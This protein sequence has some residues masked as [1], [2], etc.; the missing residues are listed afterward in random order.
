MVFGEERPFRLANTSEQSD[1]LYLRFIKTDG[2]G[3]KMK[4]DFPKLWKIKNRQIVGPQLLGED[5]TYKI[6]GVDYI[7]RKLWLVKTTS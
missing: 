1:Q 2:D 7:S 6:V 3:I 5:G 4:G